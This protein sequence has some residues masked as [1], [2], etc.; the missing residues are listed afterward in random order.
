[1]IF[2]E[3]SKKLSNNKRSFRGF[4]KQK[5]QQNARLVSGANSESSQTNKTE[6]STKQV[7]NK[8]VTIFAEISI[9]HAQSTS[10]LVLTY[11]SKLHKTF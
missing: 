10:K 11:A 6:K 7:N 8:P 9:L 1:M 2:I 4:I 3:L 5:L